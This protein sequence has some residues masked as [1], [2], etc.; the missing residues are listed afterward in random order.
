MT[1]DLNPCLFYK[2]LADDTRLKLILLITTV[3]EAC[4]CDLMCALEIDQPT[5]S[6]HLAHIRKNNILIGDKRG[7]WV[8]YQ[9]NP[10]LPAW[11]KDVIAQTSQ[12]NGDYYAKALAK[13]KASIKLTNAI[14]C[15]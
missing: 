10:Q 15:C 5:T 6:R 1:T 9:L 12:A 2:C 8:Y 7:K 14:A 13:L 3:D 11:A 4:V